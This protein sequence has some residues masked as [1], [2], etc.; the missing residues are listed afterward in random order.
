M[1]KPARKNRGGAWRDN[2]LSSST[3]E[4]EALQIVANIADDKLVARGY[5]RTQGRVLGHVHTTM[6]ECGPM[7]TKTE[8]IAGLLAGIQ[9]AEEQKNFNILQDLQ[10]LQ[11]VYPKTA[12]R[13]YLQLLARL[14]QKY[15][16]DEAAEVHA[17]L[18]KKC[19]AGDT[20]AIR[21]WNEM[22][23]DNQA[24]GEGVQIIDDL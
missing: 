14:I 23:K 7:R 8:S 9:Q 24:T 13:D 12:K 6:K 18:L 5:F 16:V 21:L 20:D 17:A 11:K 4:L 10:M 22:A 2:A 19:R 15:K 3:F 1:A